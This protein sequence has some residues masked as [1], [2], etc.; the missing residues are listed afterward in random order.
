MLNLKELGKFTEFWEYFEQISKIP[1][2][3]EHEENIRIFI[4]QEAEKLGFISQV[5]EAGNLVVRY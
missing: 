2:C 4:K 5:D 3:S 1:R